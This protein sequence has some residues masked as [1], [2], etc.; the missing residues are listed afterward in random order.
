MIISYST[1]W[2]FC[3]LF[4]SLLFGPNRDR[5]A[6]SKYGESRGI[7][8]VLVGKPEGKNHL[9]DPGLDGRIIL[10]WIFRKLYVGVWTGSR[11][12]R[13]GTVGGLL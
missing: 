4:V 10:R 5:V 7:Y 8:R 1:F 13:I 3:K 6:C 9:E 11:W 12:V 2:F